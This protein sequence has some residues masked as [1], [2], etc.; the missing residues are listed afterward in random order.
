MEGLTGLGLIT[1]SAICFGTNSIFARL[2]YE[3]G[4]DP[5]TYHFFRFLIASPV[6]FVIMFFRGY[7]IPRGKLLGGRF[8]LKAGSFQAT[9]IIIIISAFIYGLY[10][11]FQGFRL[12]MA[13]YGWAA[14]TA[15]ALFSIALGISES[16]WRTNDNG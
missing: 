2:S 3:A 5:T 9:S 8:M 4:A 10:I 12:P 7:K 16:C 13:F 15:S 1:L 14:V 6:M 11:G